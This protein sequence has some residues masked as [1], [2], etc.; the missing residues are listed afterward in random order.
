MSEAAGSGSGLSARVTAA[1]RADSSV[2]FSIAPFRCDITPPLGHSL[3]GGWIEPVKAIDDNLEAIGY[4]LLGA[5]APIV[6]C[7]LDWAGLLN[8][9]H[10]RWRTTLAL[11]AGTSPDRVAVHCVHQHN[12]PFICPEARAAAARHADLPEMY[13][14]EFFERCL[15]RAAQALQKALSHAQPVTH[16]AH[17]EARVEGVASNRRVDRGPDGRIQEMRLSSCTDPRLIALPEGTIDPMLQTIA[18]YAPDGRKIVACH[19][20]ATHPMSFY[21]DGRVTSD[22]CGL[23]RKRRQAAD[24]DCTH[25]YF[26]GCAGNISAGKYNDGSPA[27]RVIL[28]ERIHAGMMAAEATLVPEPLAHVGWR[29]EQVLPPPLPHPTV[30]EL[31]VTIAD[32]RLSL[33]ERLVPAFR[34]GWLRR[35]E[36]GTPFVLSCLQLNAS[37]IVHLPGEMFIEYQLRARARQADGRVAVAAYGDDGLWYVPTKDE[38]PRGGYEVSA[39]FCRDDV[40]A[41]MTAAIV[42]LLEVKSAPNRR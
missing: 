26:T 27:A 29:A 19:Y 14:L 12:T 8:E 2:G 24:P 38:Y 23:A 5:D 4:V 32:S 36:Q 42:N 16:L 31:E 3:L 20:Y 35:F 7:V 6:V 18:Y 28:T 22:F 1:S 21:R 41:I 13:D 10:Q 17:G 9:A 40:D 34:L 37:S 11:A 39:A 30:A 25:L 33:A 15:D